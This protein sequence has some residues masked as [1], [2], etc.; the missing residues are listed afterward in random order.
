MPQRFCL[1]GYDQF[2]IKFHIRSQPVTGR[3]GTEGIVEAEQ[4][5]LNFLNCE[6]GDGAGEFGGKDYLIAIIS[7]FR[8]QQSIGNLQ[9]GFNRIGQA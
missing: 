8:K 7:I 9:G 2:N 1:V 6:A 3:T 5:R 4:A